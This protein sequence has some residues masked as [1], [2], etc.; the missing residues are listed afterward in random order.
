MIEL[1]S[2]LGYERVSIAQIS[3]RAGV[4]SATFYEQ[5]AGKEDCMIEAYRQARARVYRQ[6]PEVPGETE[7]IKATRVTL[8]GTLDGIQADPDAGRMLF[9]EALAGGPAMRAERERALQAY[10]AQ[11]EAYLESRPAGSETLDIPVAA[12]EGARRYIVSR[13]L[14]IRAEDRLPNLAEHLLGWVRSYLAPAARGRWSAGAEASLARAPAFELPPPDLSGM[15]SERLPRGRH[16][17]PPSFVA[18]SQRMRIIA[19]T[20][21]VMLENGYTGTTVSDIVSSAAVSRDVFYEHFADKQ[22][23]FLETQQFATQYV[24]DTCAAAY[25]REEDWPMRVWAALGTLLTLIAT[26]PAFAHVRLVECYAAGPSAIRISEEVL[27]SAGI[28]LEQGFSYREEARALPR[29]STQ[30]ITGGVLEIIYR[31]VARGEAAHLPLR[32]PQLT[33]VVLAPFT[34]AEQ[35]IELVR[36]AVA[37]QALAGDTQPG[38]P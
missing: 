29:L 10:E 30:A 34:G 31:H 2:E 22:N 18:R 19:A 16:G 35:A 38:S 33:Y 8:E 13:Q 27:R 25:F 24:V 28:F 9:V 12:L 4:S 17:L 26:F 32:L 37:R 21:E 3:A 1:C 36:Q 20:A 23:A 14:R 15:W 7:V 6:V 11:V 5:F